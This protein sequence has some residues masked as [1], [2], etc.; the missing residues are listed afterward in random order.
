MEKEKNTE[1]KKEKRKGE[2]KIYKLENTD[3][4]RQ[5]CAYK[6]HTERVI[7]LHNIE[8]ERYTYKSYRQKDILVKDKDL[9]TKYRQ[10]QKD[11]SIKNKIDKQKER[12]TN[13][14][15]RQNEEDNKERRN[16]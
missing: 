1:R 4:E 7:C 15:Q 14:R 13:K 12:Y 8:I 11:V 5:S 10:R 2:R 9:P 16:Q 6:R 3:S